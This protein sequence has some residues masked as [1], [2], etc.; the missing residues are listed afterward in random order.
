MDGSVTELGEFGSEHYGAAIATSDIDKYFVL[1]PGQNRTTM[2]DRMVQLTT[3][4]KL[5]SPK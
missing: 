1:R 2:F 5:N 3:K 4:N